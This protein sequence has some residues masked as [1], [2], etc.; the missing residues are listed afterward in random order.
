VPKGIF[1]SELEGVGPPMVAVGHTGVWVGNRWRGGNA[2]V[3]ID[4]AF[5]SSEFQICEGIY[6]LA[7][8]S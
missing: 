1:I 4:G 3:I 7:V 5:Y 6:S 8:T 2:F